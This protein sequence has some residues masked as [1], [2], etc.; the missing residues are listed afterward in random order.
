MADSAV[1]KAAGATPDGA[2]TALSAWRVFMGDILLAQR[3]GEERN[4]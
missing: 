2:S 1:G 3:P 4:R